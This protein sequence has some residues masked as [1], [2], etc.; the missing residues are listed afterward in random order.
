MYDVL[1]VIRSI[2]Y[3][4]LYIYCYLILT[5]PTTY[6]PLL[7]LIL[8]LSVTIAFSALRACPAKKVRKMNKYSISCK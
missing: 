3:N 4:I 1:Y 5:Y 2:I 6:N 7:I 8:S